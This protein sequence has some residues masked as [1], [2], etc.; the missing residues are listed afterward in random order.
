MNN[1]NKVFIKYKIYY[2]NIKYII[3]AKH[4]LFKYIYIFIYY[5]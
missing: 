1:N 5:I 3:N 2:N 4:F